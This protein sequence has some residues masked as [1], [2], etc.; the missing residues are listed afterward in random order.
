MEGVKYGREVGITETASTGEGQ[1][2]D[3]E[4]GRE[5]EQENGKKTRVN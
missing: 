2:R 3:G 5:N 4:R 1:L